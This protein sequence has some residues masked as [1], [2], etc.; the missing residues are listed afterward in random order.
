[1]LD[2]ILIVLCLFQPSSIEQD[3][4]SG[5]MTVKF[6]SKASPTEQDMPGEVSG[7]DCVLF[8]VGRN[9]NSHNIGLENLVR[10]RD[11]SVEIVRQI[12]LSFSD[13]NLVRDILVKGYLFSFLDDYLIHLSKMFGPLLLFGP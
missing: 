10:E 2:M 1:M 4:N 6:M 12:D 13:F 5:K 3:E 7:A 8:A 9:P 11:I